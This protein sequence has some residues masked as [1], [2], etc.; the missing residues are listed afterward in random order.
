ML[1]RNTDLQSAVNIVTDMLAQRV[2]DYVNFKAQMPSF[3]AEVDQ[4]LATY[5]KAL[6]HY[7]Q[8]TVVWYYDSPRISNLVN[9]DV[10][11][12]FLINTFAS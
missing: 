10:S 7:V 12:L 11:L 4:E 2:Q 3:G 5:F 1:E 8:G 9:W 6:E